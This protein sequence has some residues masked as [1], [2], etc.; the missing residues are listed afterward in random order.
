ML[1][2]PDTIRILDADS[3]VCGTSFNNDIADNLRFRSA[4]LD[5]VYS[6]SEI[7]TIRFEHTR[8][9]NDMSRPI[10]SGQKCQDRFV[11]PPAVL[12]ESIPRKESFGTLLVFFHR[13][14]SKHDAAIVG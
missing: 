3:Q 9:K 10:E 2:H 12:M 14:T 8:F 4:P 5:R 6:K 1:M 7:P 11:R 13:V